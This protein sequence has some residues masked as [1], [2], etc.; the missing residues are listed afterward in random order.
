MRILLV[1][2]VHIRPFAKEKA[3]NATLLGLKK[4]IQTANADLIVFLG[5]T[6][7]GP[8]FQKSTEPYEKYLH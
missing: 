2:D 4:A 1:A 3:A 7:H 8:D 6:V 5:D